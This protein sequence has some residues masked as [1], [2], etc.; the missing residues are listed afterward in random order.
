M[1]NLGLIGK[2]LQHSFSKKFFQKKFEKENLKNFSYKSY[3]LNAIEE[4]PQLLQNKNLTGLNI[5]SPYK[6][7]IIKYIDRLDEVSRKIKSVNTIFI[8]NKKITGYNTDFFGFKKSLELFLPKSKLKALVLGNG[9]VSK[10]ICY[11]L[12]EKNIEF[13]I[14]S[15]KQNAS[16]VISYESCEKY[17]NTHKLIIN[18]TILGGRKLINYTPKIN[19]KMLSKKNYMYDVIYNPKETLFLKK[20]RERGAN[21]MNG[22]KMLILQAELAFEIWRKEIQSI[23]N[24]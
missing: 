5:T 1:Y 3:E 24:V 22:K 19:Y 12:K 15:R 4:F 23:K 6:E 8:K 9:G 18:T 21:I 14:V 17:L 2:N 13:L 7:S 20:G 16:N 11:A 10:S